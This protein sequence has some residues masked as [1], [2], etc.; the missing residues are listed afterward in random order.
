MGQNQSMSPYWPV[1]RD[2]VFAR[3]LPGLA[4][5]ALGDGMSAVA[6]GWLAVQYAPQHER[7]LWVGLAVAAYTLP[8]AIGAIVVAPL[9]RGRDGAHMV[10]LDALL[11]AAFLGAVPVLAGLDLL[12]IGRYA[13]LLA[14]SALLSAWGSA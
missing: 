7:G 4:L 9:L 1:V 6:I 12:T 13:A 14:G 11:R 8:G 3:V 10:A 5:S 2:R